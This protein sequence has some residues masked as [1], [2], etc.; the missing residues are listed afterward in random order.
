VGRLAELPDELK[1]IQGAEKLLEWFGYWP[2]FHDAE[3]IALNLDRR[4]PSAVVIHT[5]EMTSQVDAKG[6]YILEKHVVVEFVLM[7]VFDV[8]LKMFNRQNVIAGL[9][10]EKI[11]GG[12]RIGLHECYGIA[13]TIDAGDIAIRLTPGKPEETARESK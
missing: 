3:V 1:T 13:G 8:D 10:L 9:R 4:L 7:G 11:E 2:S 12:F 6:Y 5:W